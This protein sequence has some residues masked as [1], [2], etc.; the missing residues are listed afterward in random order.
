MLHDKYSSMTDVPFV[1]DKVNQSFFQ[2]ISLRWCPRMSTALC[3]EKEWSKPKVFLQS[4]KNRYLSSIN[5]RQA[6]ISSNLLPYTLMLLQG[7]VAI[8]L[9]RLAC[10]SCNPSTNSSAQE[11]L[12]LWAWICEVSSSLMKPVLHKGTALDERYCWSNDRI[13]ILHRSWDMLHFQFLLFKSLLF[14]NNSNCNSRIYEL[15]LLGNTNSVETY[16]YQ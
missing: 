9:V 6:V 16:E 12:D 2:H 4:F 1:P 13:K 15:A 7:N 11:H 5:Q 3:H 8:R 14:C 10:A